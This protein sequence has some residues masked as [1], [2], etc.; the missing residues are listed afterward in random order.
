MKK[1]FSERINQIKLNSKPRTMII[2][3]ALF[4]V[5]FLLFEPIKTYLCNLSDYWFEFGEYAKLVALATLVIFIFSLFVLSVIC[6]LFPVLAKL[7]P[8]YM[9]IIIIGLYI[10][11]NFVPNTFGSLDGSSIDWMEF[12]SGMIWSVLLW[13]II[14]VVIVLVTKGKA[15]EKV[16]RIICIVS[17]LIILLEIVT[18]ISLMVSNP[19]F[20]GENQEYFI[21]S[22]EEM[23][24]SSDENFIILVMDC[25]DSTYFG[26]NLPSN[27][28]E[29]L[30]GFTYYP[31]TASM[32]G[33]TEC[34]LAEIITGIPFINETSFEEYETNAFDDSYLLNRL[35]KDDWNIGIYADYAF[36]ENNV[37]DKSVN[38]KNLVPKINSKRKFYSNVY[39]IVAYNIVPYHFKQFLW[40]YPQ[41]NE[42]KGVSA[43]E[44]YEQYSF[45]NEMFYGDIDDIK[46]ADDNPRF[47]FYHIEGMHTPY[48]TTKD[49]HDSDV[50]VSYDEILQANYEIIVKFLNNLKINGVYDN[51][52]IIIM[53][54]HGG[55]DR[56][57]G[58]KQNP[59]FLYKGID[60][61]HQFDISKKKFSYE[62]IN[63]IYKGI[64]E[65]LNIDDII[66]ENEGARRLFYFYIYDTMNEM[67]EYEIDG[68]AW[69]NNAMHKTG[70]M[71][72]YEEQ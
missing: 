46:V 35:V 30:E 53:S 63:E 7:V 67:T 33:H 68:N 61:H 54:D 12:N 4:C 31:D 47:R 17:P 32:Y 56:V 65:G 59:M 69:D 24:F 58:L 51:S 45:N 44:E 10:Q 36:H 1:F 38:L 70:N 40:F 5:S 49:V 14:I 3:L 13:L 71:M 25:F 8:A 60:S 39:R 43:D 11:G 52:S 27:V 55:Y 64:F 62:K 23:E 41:L 37:L 6:L 9:F 66:A 2:A 15:W 72:V 26:E 28:K 34:S 42:L 29:T 21:S 57:E 16:E 19:K 20:S 48:M 22:N 50:E 18:V